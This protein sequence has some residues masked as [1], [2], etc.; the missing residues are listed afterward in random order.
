MHDNSSVFIDP[1]LLVSKKALEGLWG[2]TESNLELYT[3]DA[4][5]RAIEEG[6]RHRDESIA[7]PAA[8][9][10]QYLDPSALSPPERIVEYSEAL[11]LQPYSGEA[12]KAALEDSHLDIR[13]PDEFDTLGKAVT[14]EEI[15]FL[16]SQCSVLSRLKRREN[17]IYESLRRWLR[18]EMPLSH[19][20]VD[21]SDGIEDG[22]EERGLSSL[23]SRGWIIH[24]AAFGA[25]VGVSLGLNLF[26][27]GATFITAAV[28]RLIVVSLDQ[29][30]R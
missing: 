4:F 17:E 23:I 7:R 30:S 11:G 20:T 6:L 21:D 15:G 1:T 28:N 5:L 13:L 22:L 2:L 25:D 10:A 8:P 29:K 16:F 18:D 19:L 27:P 26:L 9:F 24:I 3:S 12:S 14:A